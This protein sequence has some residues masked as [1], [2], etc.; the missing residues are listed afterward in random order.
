MSNYN[1]CA[2]EGNFTRDPE[3]ETKNEKSICKFSIANNDHKDE[4][5]YIDC[6]AF[7]KTAEFIQKFFQKGKSII[8]ECLYKQDRWED[9]T[10]GYPRSKPTFIVNKASFCGNKS[11]NGA[12]K[13]DDPFA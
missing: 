11:D 3:L 12:A 9:K 1:Y 5:S 6:V 4:V 2:F 10:T 7:N 13:S 8:I